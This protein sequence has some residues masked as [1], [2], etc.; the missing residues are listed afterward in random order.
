MTT[1]LPPDAAMRDARRRDEIGETDDAIRGDDI[2]FVTAG[3]DAETQAAVIAVLTQARA[4]ETERA[5]R[6]AR[7]D[8]APWSRSQRVPESTHAADSG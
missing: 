1:P 7:R 2:S 6:V 3:V 4:E 5:K 8:R